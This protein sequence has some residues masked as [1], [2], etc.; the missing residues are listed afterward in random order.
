RA[1]KATDVKSRNEALLMGLALTQAETWIAKRPDDIPAADR[2]FIMLSSRASQQKKLRVQARLWGVA[3]GEAIAIFLGF[4]IW[5]N[6]SF[7]KEQWNWNATMLP[8]RV[9]NFDP[10]VL[11]PEAERALKPGEPFREC[12]TDCPEM[13]VVPAG[14]FMM[15]APPDEP[16][17]YDNE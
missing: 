2:Q 5:V 17:R 16:F 10:Y 8:Y 11:K 4:L 1:W 7:V 14:R 15:G 13:I 9:A 3:I 12:A 6:Q